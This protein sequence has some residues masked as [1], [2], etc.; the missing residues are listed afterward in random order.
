MLYYNIDKEKRTVVAYSDKDA[1]D[2]IDELLQDVLTRSNLG[3]LI[4]FDI[5]DKIIFHVYNREPV[6]GIAKCHPNDIFDEKLGKIVAKNKY[7]RTISRLKVAALKE[8]KKWIAREV[9]SFDD[10]VDCMIRRIK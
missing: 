8:L 1:Y 7:K 3:Y 9:Y 4:T 2:Q 6:V 10:I 5:I